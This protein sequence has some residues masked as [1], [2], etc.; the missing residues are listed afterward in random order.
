MNALE[1][2]KAYMMDVQTAMEKEVY[3][4]DVKGLIQV[5]IAYALIAIADAQQSVELI[6]EFNDSIRIYGPESEE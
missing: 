3:Q 2:A 5:A 1:L 6:S 4:P